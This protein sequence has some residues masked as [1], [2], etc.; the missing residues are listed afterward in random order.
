[1]DPSV[2][3][4][5]HTTHAVEAWCTVS[6]PVTRRSPRGE[7]SH[8]LCGDPKAAHVSHR[9]GAVA[10]HPRRAVGLIAPPVA[11]QSSRG[12][13]QWYA[14]SGQ[15]Q[16]FTPVQSCGHLKGWSWSTGSWPVSTTKSTTA[17][18]HV[19][20]H[21][22]SWRAHSRNRR[23]GSGPSAPPPVRAWVIA[24]PPGWG[25]PR[26][27]APTS[28][29][30][31]R[32]GPGLRALPPELLQGCMDLLP[33]FGDR[34]RM[35]A[36]CMAARFLE[37]RSAPP[38]R[39]SEEL[40]GLGLGD[41]GVHAVA[42]AFTTP[43]GRHA[44]IGELCLGNNRIGDTGARAIA[45]VLGAGSAIRRLSLRDNN[46]GDVGAQAIATALSANSVLEEL[47][48]WGNE[49][50]DTGKWALLS[51][52][53]C[54]VFLELDP[55]LRPCTSLT[56]AE[57]FAAGRMRAV[58]FDWIS[59]VHTG[60]SA[61]MALDG[62]PDPQDMLFRTFS[63]ADAYLS[64]QSVP[65]AELQ[66][67]GV[68]CTL[69]AAGLDGRSET[70]EDAELANWLAFVTDGACTAN[71]VRDAAHEVHSALG[72]KLHQPTAYTF[73]RRYLRRTGWTE[74]S[75]SLANY[76]IELAA[77]DSTFME[78]RPQAVAAAAAVLSRQYCTQGVN[79]QHIPGWRAKL[80]RCAR[81]D[82]RR[83]LAPCVATM[84]RIHAA[85][86]SQMG[87]F[88]NR[89]YEWPRLHAVAKIM[90]NPPPD[91]AFFVSYLSADHNS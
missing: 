25:P 51:V 88:V 28:S 63:L 9:T 26:R 66:L 86:H 46:I 76:L 84:A 55:P 14:S 43:Q 30:A 31:S 79:V 13:P 81:L 53:R 32:H 22:G 17:A 64:R 59:Q 60:G 85:E 72:F 44:A 45:A 33:T 74:E 7:D 35:C 71:Q 6:S 29:R 37:W 87:K 2:G 57:A 27:V 82:L 39:P 19:A 48:L 12:V 21:T 23:P 90:P 42:R 69:A 67:C 40:S 34:A 36:V 4:G 10:V 24:Y 49:L 68:A 91:A 3:N 70:E 54:K 83:E 47:D 1:M 73:L 16:S 52:A 65:K 41:R 18:A 5:C 61:P 78:Y 80:L 75:F 11:V 62:A 56:A 38:L 77:I 58:L 8:G 89:K 50:S 15:L 20:H